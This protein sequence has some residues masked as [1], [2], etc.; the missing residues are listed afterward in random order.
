MSTKRLGYNLLRVAVL[1]VS[2]VCFETDTKSIKHTHVCGQNVELLG[3]FEK[4]QKAII[5]F[6][7]CV[8]LSVWNNSAHTEKKNSWNVIFKGFFLN[9][10]RKLKFY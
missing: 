7:V 1:K 9:F 2:H 3:A 10:S 5:N 4:L 8:R 6:V